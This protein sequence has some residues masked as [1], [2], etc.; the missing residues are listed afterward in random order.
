MRSNFR[1]SICLSVLA[2]FFYVGNIAEAASA[3]ADKNEGVTAHI[4]I[5]VVIPVVLRLLEDSHPALL[6]VSGEREEDQTLEQRI[7]MLST[8]RKG[9][10]ADLRLGT[11]SVASWKLQLKAGSGARLETTATGYR[12]CFSRAGR[13]E[14]ALSHN[15]GL[16]ARQADAA[17][18][19]WPVY[20]SFAAP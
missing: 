13:H 6:R 1:L 10:C 7:V 18:L 12:L 9:F 3:L 19:D 15:F 4:D 17:S 16:A 8:V 20:L 2:G 11:A 5:R 14:L